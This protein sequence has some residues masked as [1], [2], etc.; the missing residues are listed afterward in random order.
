MLTARDTVDDRVPPSA[1][2]SAVHLR[3]EP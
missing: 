3:D 2:E 1:E